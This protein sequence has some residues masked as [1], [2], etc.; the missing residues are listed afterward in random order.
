MERALSNGSPRHPDSSD[1]DED[2]V[3]RDVLSWFPTG[4]VAITGRSG[5]TASGLTV[6][7]FFSVSLRPRMVGFCV[8]KNSS[9]WSF[10]RPTGRFCVNI[11]AAD[12]RAVSESLARPG[13]RDK[14]DMVE[15][16]LSEHGLPLVKG[17]L[18]WMTCDVIGEQDA[19]DHSVVIG[20]VRELVLSR[21]ERP[22][23]FFRREYH[24]TQ[25]PIL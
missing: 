3:F 21:E 10:L 7:S 23:I 6:G 18:A 14:L 13:A 16:E 9:T 24:S 22:L 25:S 11:L 12:Q 1:R 17:A 15:W 5:D 20:A 2:M 4:V 8:A 19:G